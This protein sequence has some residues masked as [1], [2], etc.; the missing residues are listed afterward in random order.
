MAVSLD[1]NGNYKSMER[2]LPD[3][4]FSSAIDISFGPD[5]DLYVLEYGSAWFK[6]NENAQLVRVEYNAGNRKPVVEVLASKRSGALPFK[7]QLLSTG[8]S[9]YDGDALKYEWRI[10]GGGQTKILRDPNPSL[11]LSK[12]G[13]YKAS[14]TVTDA[15]GAKATK[16]LELKAGNEPPA[17]T[18]DLAKSNRTFY[19]PGTTLNYAVMVQDKE[20]GS[21]QTGKI[22]PA[23]VALSIDY[24]PL[25]YDQIDASATHRGADAKAFTSTGQILLAKNDCK[26]CHMPNKRSV[27]PSYLEVAKKYKGT[28]GASE[29]LAQKVIKG[30]SGVWGDH[31]MSAHPQLSVTDSRAIVEY[32]LSSGD[33]KAVVKS[34]PVKGTYTTK[35]SE[36]QKEKG[37]YI[38][39]AAYRDRGTTSM[40]PIVGEDVVLLRHPSLD[41][42]LA[43]TT[44]GFNKVITPSKAMYM[45]GNGAY[46]AYDDIDL[47][48]ISAFVFKVNANA[49]VAATGGTIEVRLDTPDGTLAGQ[50]SLV[51]AKGGMQSP[52]A[53]LTSAS[54]KHKVYFV[55]KNDKAG[56]NQVVLQVLSIDVKL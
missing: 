19:T 25:G 45:Q 9:D 31:A 13:I 5:G 40:A 35:P 32:I 29:S 10:T 17:V 36:E 54:G 47:T 55:F 38:L 44:K 18:V 2:F 28:P 26:S 1:E 8:T 11:T 3:Q 16:T 27:G 46:L 50:T 7:T 56:P 14:L 42:E 12:P 48:G 24:L 37:T 51:D 41:P 30:G 39:R 21:L 22:K 43:N 53:E 4:N 49:R 15:Q 52:A 20:D 34:M 23:Q 33:K 6:G